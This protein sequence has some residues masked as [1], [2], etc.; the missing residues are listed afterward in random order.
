MQTYTQSMTD[1][2]SLVHLFEGLFKIN[3]IIGQMCKLP[4]TYCR[5]QPETV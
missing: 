3:L 4:E 1:I 5:I 2:G